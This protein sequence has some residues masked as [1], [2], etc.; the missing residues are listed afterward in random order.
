M[1]LMN[2]NNPTST[3]SWTRLIM[4][5]GDQRCGVLGLSLDSPPCDRCAGRMSRLSTSEKPSTEITTIGISRQNE[6]ST[7][8][9]SSIGTKA[10]S[11]VMTAR[12]TGLATRNVPLIAPLAPWV[13]A[14]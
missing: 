6:P 8:E 4:P 14:S 9:I 3:P 10:M 11:V 13:P 7:P 12:N 5:M 1:R 2:P